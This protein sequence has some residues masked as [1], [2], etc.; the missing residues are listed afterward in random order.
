MNGST[1][2]STATKPM[3]ARSRPICAVRRRSGNGTVR[4]KNGAQSPTASP[5]PSGRP[6]SR[7]APGSATGKAIPSSGKDASRPLSGSRC[8]SRPSPSP[9]RW[10]TGANSRQAS[11]GPPPPP[12]AR[13]LCPPVFGVGTRHQR[14][15]QW[16]GA[17]ISPQRDRLR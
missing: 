7:S 5:S 14:E 1:S 6:S 15:H 3:A 10:T 13:L 8:P 11:H 17:A 12:D 4:I 2:I 16:P 9:S